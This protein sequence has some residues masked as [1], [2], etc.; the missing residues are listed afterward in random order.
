[1]ELEP[2]VEIAFDCLPLRCVGRVDVPLDASPAYRER[3]QRLRAAIE[4]FGD[5]N[6]YF[7]YN[8]R[9]VYRLANSEIEGMLRFEFEG[10]VV[11]GPD[12]RQASQADLEVKLAAET[13]GGV[14]DGV[15]AWLV[16][17]VKHAVLIEF[18]R[19]IA[20]GSLQRA[21]DELGELDSIDDLA[22]FAGMHL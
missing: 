6:A 3:C 5:S 12:D 17:Q 2:V 22:S 15:L 14:P 8:A 16:R 7:L 4:Q 11:T 18:D 9:C 1:M 20:A 19:Y 10:T 13:C 21:M